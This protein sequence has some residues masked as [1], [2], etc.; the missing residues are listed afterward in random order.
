VSAEASVLY[1]CAN[2][3]ARAQPPGMSWKLNRSKP[4]LLAEAGVRARAARV[5]E[6]AGFEPADFQMHEARHSYR[7]FLA[8][9]GIPR[10]RR[11]RYLG[12]ADGSVGSRYEH[13]LEH[14]YLDDARTLGEYLTRAD[15][16][17]RIE[18]LKE[19][20]IQDEVRVSRATVRD[21]P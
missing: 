20:E 1:R 9:A 11:D 7:T 14:Q 3:E 8:A 15:T 17:A 12:H 6:D 2:A 16:T 4:A 21:A 18:E 13:Q 5:L 19:I 10:D